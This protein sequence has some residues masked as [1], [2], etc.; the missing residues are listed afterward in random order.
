MQVFTVLAKGIT[1]ESGGREHPHSGS[2]LSL[3][4]VLPQLLLLLLVVP[5]LKLTINQN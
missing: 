1:A 4:P 5:V 3:Q 2:R